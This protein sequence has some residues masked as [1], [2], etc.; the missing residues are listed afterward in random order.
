MAFESAAARLASGWAVFGD[1]FAAGALRRPVGGL[2]SGFR[3]GARVLAAPFLLAGAAISAGLPARRVLYAKDALELGDALL[4]LLATQRRA[5]RIAAQGGH[6]VDGAATCPTGEAVPA[7]PDPAVEMGRRVRVDV[8]RV[9]TADLAIPAGLCAD[10][11]PVVL[12]RL[13]RAPGLS[14]SRLRRAAAPPRR[15]RGLGVA[16]AGGEEARAVGRL[17]QVAHHH[18][19]PGGRAALARRLV[20]D[21][22]GHPQDA[23]PVGRDRIGA[24]RCRQ[25]PVERL[26]ALAGEL[27]GQEPVGVGAARAGGDDRV[28]G[29]GEAA[30]GA[31]PA[32]VVDVD[33]GDRGPVDRVVAGDRNAERRGSE[34]DLPTHAGAQSLHPLEELLAPTGAHEVLEV[35]ALKAPKPTVGQ[36]RRADQLDEARPAAVDQLGEQRR[37]GVGAEDPID[38][39]PGAIAHRDRLGRPVEGCGRSDG[40]SRRARHAH[41]PTCSGARSRA[42]QRRTAVSAAATRA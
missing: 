4:E 18:P 39:P 3:C 41:N 19:A 8:G 31:E 36:A 15:A 33:P 35:G 25:H 22:A 26:A 9:G 12:G 10:D 27:V 7:A 2:A 28:R 6:Q 17:G 16:K 11:R 21:G 1:R 38:S 30:Q 37:V 14:S 32:R 24:K 13:H 40:C 29:V 34:E 42:S 20:V 5:G 23:P